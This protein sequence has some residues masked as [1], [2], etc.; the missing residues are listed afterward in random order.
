MEV[1]IVKRDEFVLMNIDDG[2]LNLMSTDGAPKDD[3]KVPEGELGDLIQALFEA[4]DDPNKAGGPVVVTILNA[5][6]EEA[7]IAA[8]EGPKDG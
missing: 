5:M 4:Q 2:F 6:G 1:P 3:V 8:K 7:A